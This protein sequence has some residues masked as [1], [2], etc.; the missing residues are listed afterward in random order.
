MEDE[1]G[2][3]RGVVGVV[4][5]V[6]DATAGDSQVGHDAIGVDRQ[7]DSPELCLYKSLRF[8]FVIEGSAFRDGIAELKSDRH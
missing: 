7:L 3:G 1:R 2:A 8:F 5:G 4:V 6:E